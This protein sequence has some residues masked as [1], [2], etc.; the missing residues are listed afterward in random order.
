MV[1]IC[2][3]VGCKP[4]GGLGPERLKGRGVR[5]PLWKN[6]FREQDVMG[7][8]RGGVGVGVDKVGEEE[9]LGAYLSPSSS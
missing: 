2:G 6:E 8:D 5:K 4:S 3:S 1:R 9:D 7:W